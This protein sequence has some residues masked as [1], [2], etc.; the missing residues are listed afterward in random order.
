M[1]IL[2]DGS[3]R[4][5]KKMFRKSPYLNEYPV[6]SINPARLARYVLRKGSHDFQLSTA[7]VAIL[8]LEALDEKDNAAAFGAWFDLFVEVSKHG[9]NSMRK[10]VLRPLPELRQAFLSLVSKGE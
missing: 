4:E 7:E 6:L 9:R 5:A 3:W 10:S 8:V 2:L 1:F